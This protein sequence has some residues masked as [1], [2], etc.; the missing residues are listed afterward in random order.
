MV[1]SLALA[2]AWSAPITAAGSELGRPL[3]R[4]FP[5]AEHKA[6]TQFW[7]PF[8]SAEGLMYFGNQL[9]V[10][11]FDGRTW[12]VLK[13]PLPFTRALAAGPGGDIYLGDEEQLGVLARP[14]SGPPQYTSL[15][16]R[17]PA[18]AKPFGFV[19]DVCQWRGDVFFA[20]DKNVLRWRAGAFRAWPMPGGFRHRLFAVGGR[21]LLHRQGEALYEFDGE[22]FRRFSAAPEL[23]K[24]GFSFIAPAADDSLLVGLEEQGLFLLG[25]QGALTPWRHAAEALLRESRI[26]CGLRLRD[27][28]VAIGTLS[29]GIVVLDAGGRVLRRVTREAGLPHATV[30]A[31]CEDRDDGLW[32]C[33]NN[34]PARVLW[35]SA[36]TI[37]DYQ[38]SGLSDARAN[39]LERHDGTLYY[40]CNDGL[41]RLVPSGS[42]AVPAHFERDPRVKVQTKLSSLLSHRGGLLLAGGRGLE[43]LTDRGLE[44]LTAVPDGLMGLTAAATDPNRVFFAHNRGIGTGTFAADGTWRD[45]GTVPGIA[46]E[47]FDVLESADGALWAGTVSKGVFRATRAPGAPDWR[48]AVTR[49]FTTADGLPADHGTIYLWNTPVGVLFDT[50]QGIYRFEAASERFIFYRELVSFE[51]RPIVLNPVA[52]GAAGDLWTNG[53]IN[54]V[55]T[56]ETPYPLIRLRRQPDGRFAMQEAAPELQDFFAPRAPYRILWEPAARGAGVLWCVGD[57]G[58]ARVELDHY[59]P[60]NPDRS[61]LIRQIT[62]EG[63]DLTFP[64][65][66]PGRVQLGFSREPITATFV[67]GAMRRTDMERFQTRL[68][69]FNDEWSAPTTHNEATF[70]N[71]ERGPFRFEVRNVGRDGRAGPAT[72]FTFYVTPPWQRSNLAYATYALAGLGAVFGFIRWRLRYAERERARLERIVAQ[73]TTELAAAKEQADAANQAKSA[74]LASMSHELRTPLN[75][76]IGYAQVLMNDRELSGKNRERL[77]V[78]QTSGEHLLR[79]INEVLDLSK[80][81]AGRM[82]LHPAP[83][84]LPQLLRDIAAAISTRAEEK[85]IEFVFAPASHL[86]EMVIGDAQKL[87]QILDNLLSNAIKFTAAGSVTLRVGGHGDVSAHLQAGEPDAAADHL[88]TFSVTDTGAGISDRDRARI[89][90]PFQ[91]ATDARPPE[92]GTGLG[93]TIS[94]RF[95]ALMGGELSVESRLGS[96]SC[97]SFEVRLPRLAVDPKDVSGAARTITGYTGSRRSVLLVDDVT[98]NRHVLRD[99]LQPLGFEIFEA[100]SGETALA[101]AAPDLAF[102]D[103]RLPGMSG[104]ELARRLRAQPGGDRVRLIAM[105][106]SVLSLDQTDA[107]A[108]GC[109]DF[110]P[111]PFREADLLEKLGRLLHLE[112]TY[113]EAGAPPPVEP[114][115]RLDAAA[116]AELLACAQRGEIVALR[117]RLAELRAQGADPLL[118]TLDALARSYRM[119]EIRTVLARQLAAH[120]TSAA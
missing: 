66:N 73:R 49:Q 34:G 99:L 76:V 67:S 112:W 22:R 105:S 79:M 77:R 80:I 19:R 100:A 56:K 59:E 54:D 50:A 11:E 114:A 15:L 60:A 98:V 109:D 31:L 46:A 33:T 38:T 106:A 28:S 118:A 78:V 88:V 75:G 87:R 65:H 47:C 52:G 48:N 55:K 83:F 2:F 26:M 12:R 21:L 62:A 43:R 32:A 111:K 13:I 96:G 36:A 37:F 93:L 116:L 69:G 20:T 71:L 102:L 8:Q 107:F 7:A 57:T 30:F 81:E 39:D 40:L 45:S 117:A 115:V 10:M 70:T 44:L 89:F 103:L 58:V 68:V 91:Q 14:D 110:L 42:E 6:Y 18:E 4:A 64:R 16:D 119:E 23:A 90:Q 41:Y 113:A 53:I 1:C 5:R 84:H 85:E 51:S 3:I 29:A 97:F 72:A 86:P 35:R 17:V 92:P 82:E 24:P 120:A 63:R 108:A 61:P 104:L 74:F 9:A 95:V 101:M 27:G 94:Q 25:P